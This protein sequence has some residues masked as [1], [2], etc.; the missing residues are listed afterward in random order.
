MVFGSFLYVGKI[1]G[2][3]PRFRSR[4]VGV[5]G[6]KLREFGGEKVMFSLGVVNE[7]VN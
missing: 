2:F 6:E 3:V 5:T 4:V 1:S 7:I